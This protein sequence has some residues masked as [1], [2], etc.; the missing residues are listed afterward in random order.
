[1]VL[2]VAER[3]VLAQLVEQRLLLDP[4]LLLPVLKQVEH[5]LLYRLQLPPV[6]PV[7]VLWI[8]LET[9]QEL[10]L[11]TRL[12]LSRCFLLSLSLCDS[13]L[14]LGHSIFPIELPVIIMLSSNR[15]RRRSLGLLPFL[16]LLLGLGL[17][18]RLTKLSHG[19]LPIVFPVVVRSRCCCRGR[20]RSRCLCGL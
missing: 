1:M 15:G 6:F 3:I 18:D 20:C 17:R 13:L 4:V 7:L 19:V 8:V 14:K 12:V 9:P 5:H 2:E 10:V 11:L 16:L